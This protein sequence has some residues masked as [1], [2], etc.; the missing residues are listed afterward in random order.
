M[1]KIKM[2]PALIFILCAGFCNAQVPVGEHIKKTNY[3]DVDKLDCVSDF[4]YV[5]YTVYTVINNSKTVFAKGTSMS[6]YNFWVSV[7]KEKHV[8]IKFSTILGDEF[9]EIMP[10]E[11]R[12]FEITMVFNTKE[13]MRK[14]SGVN[15][16]PEYD[17]HLIPVSITFGLLC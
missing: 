12:D 1:K 7:P 10:W 5:N 11:D 9:I 2:M 6:H 4:P 16:Y 3:I 17:K 13:R 8:F 14:F 15:Q